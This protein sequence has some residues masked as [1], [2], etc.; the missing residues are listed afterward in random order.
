MSMQLNK[1]AF[2]LIELLVVIAVIGILSG[3]IVVSMS[4]TSQKAT[5][6]KGQVFSNSIRNALMLDL[7]QE[8]KFDEG[9]G[10]TTIDYW[11]NT[12]GTLVGTNHPPTWKTD[13]VYGGCIQFDSSEDYVTTTVNIS[14]DYSLEAWV[15]MDA[16]AGGAT[17][18]L[19]VFSANYPRFNIS[20]GATNRN[21]LYLNSA[22]YKYGTTNCADGKWHHVYFTVV[23]T[24]AADIAKDKIYID[25][26]EETYGS[27][28]STLDPI[29]PT[30]TLTIGNYS[31]STID[32]VRVYDTVISAYQIKE[33][34]YLGLNNL[35]K[36]GGISKEEY[37]NRI[38]QLA[39]E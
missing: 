13:C 21:L 26:K 16:T 1:L 17:R 6:A 35:L 28:S 23:G 30:T 33:N 9:A 12:T 5:V 39:Y 2:T 38:N 37:D 4:G 3:L 11:N 32:N 14:G 19:A 31:Y 8:W 24:L 25:G 10:P 20:H 7:V 34:Y 36:N 18:V 27:T 15:K 29:P 22:N